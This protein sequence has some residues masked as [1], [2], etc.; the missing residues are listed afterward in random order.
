MEYNIPQDFDKI[1]NGVAYTTK[2][3]FDKWFKKTIKNGDQIKF[4]YCSCLED[5]FDKCLEEIGLNFYSSVFDGKK[6]YFRLEVYDNSA[7]SDCDVRYTYIVI[8]KSEITKLLQEI[9]KRL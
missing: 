4:T 1:F 5:K 2:P 8:P 9:K 3:V 7:A 6:F